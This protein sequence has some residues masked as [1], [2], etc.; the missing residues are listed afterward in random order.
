MGRTQSGQSNRRNRL[1][2]KSYQRGVNKNLAQTGLQTIGYRIKAQDRSDG[3]QEE[4]I[5]L[6]TFPEK[7]GC[8]SP[9][10]HKR[11]TPGLHLPQRII[12]G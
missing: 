3:E 12:R 10:T 11:E 1:S 5:T 2:P 7:G 9:H 6:N 4:M 8:P